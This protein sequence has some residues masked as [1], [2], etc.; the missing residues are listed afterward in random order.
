VLRDGRAADRKLT[1][2]LADRVGTLGQPL[3]D[4]AT[5]GVTERRPSISLVSYHER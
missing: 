1:R 3:E 2:E 5:S 4:R